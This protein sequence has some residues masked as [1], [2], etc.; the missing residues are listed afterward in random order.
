LGSFVSRICPVMVL[1]L[2][3]VASTSLPG[4]R[5]S[6][7]LPPAVRSC[8]LRVFTCSAVPKKTFGDLPFSRPSPK[9]RQHLHICFAIPYKIILFPY[10][11]ISALTQHFPRRNLILEVRLNLCHLVIYTAAILSP[12]TI[13]LCFLLFPLKAYSTLYPFLL[14]IIVFSIVYLARPSISPKV[15]DLICPS[16]ARVFHPKNPAIISRDRI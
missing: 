3:R 4:S 14:S 5:Q 16:S 10:P 12:K 1:F 2:A 9:N 11:S 13:L 15:S 7:Y 6:R 8:R